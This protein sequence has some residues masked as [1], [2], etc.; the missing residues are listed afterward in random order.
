MRP[1]LILN[2]VPCRRGKYRSLYCLHRF[3]NERYGT[4]EWAIFE[5]GSVVDKDTV[6]VGILLSWKLCKCCSGRSIVVVEVDWNNHTA[7]NPLIPLDPPTISND[8][9]P[10]LEDVLAS[11]VE[12]MGT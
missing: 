7:D 4:P 6:H 3:N 8:Y 12:R 1:I 9:P 10:P 5:G 2:G 11:E